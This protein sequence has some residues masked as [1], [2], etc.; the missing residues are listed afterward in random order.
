MFEHDRGVKG[1]I[2]RKLVVRKKGYELM[3]G[4]QKLLL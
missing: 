2:I 1:G 4:K 3:T